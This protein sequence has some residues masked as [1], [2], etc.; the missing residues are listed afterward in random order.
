MRPVASDCLWPFYCHAE[1]GTGRN[2]IAEP[3][4]RTLRVYCFD[5]SAGNFVGNI[6]PVANFSDRGPLNS[7]AEDAPGRRASSTISLNPPS[8]EPVIG[9][10]L[11]WFVFRIEAPARPPEASRAGMYSARSVWF[12]VVVAQRFGGL[13]VDLVATVHDAVEDFFS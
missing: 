1:Q 6:L 4:T 13:K 9:L 7:V 5:P 10:C 3:A 2:K 8:V 12:T 11:G